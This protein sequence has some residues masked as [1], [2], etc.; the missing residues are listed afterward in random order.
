MCFAVL[1]A[2]AAL[3]QDKDNAPPQP[4]QGDNGPSLQVTMKFIQEKLTDKSNKHYEREDIVA[5]PGSCHLTITD[6]GT[7]KGA[8]TVIRSFSLREVEKIQVGPMLDEDGQATSAFVL[9]ISMDSQTGVHHTFIYDKKHKKESF[10]G[11]YRFEFSDEDIANRVA[12]AMIH[13]V[14][15]CGGG[16]KP[17]PF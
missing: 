12:K 7:A 1:A 16:S 8:T 13:A 11:G 14:E 5:D 2:S 3:A 6:S 10:A 15:L 17:E 9:R 4:K